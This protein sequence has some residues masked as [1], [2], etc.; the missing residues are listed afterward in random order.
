MTELNPLLAK[1]KMPGKVFQLP[2]RGLLYSDN[3]LAPNISNG[4]LHIQP[5]NAFDEVILKNPDMLFTGQALDPVF[6]ACIQ[7]VQKPTSLLGRDVDAIMLFLRLVT[8]GPSYEILANH[9]CEFGVTHTYV[10]DL[11]QII[12]NMKYL[13]PTTIQDQYK[14]MFENGQVVELT[15]AKYFE[16]IQIL[17]IN[18]GKTELSA[19]DL[20]QNIHNNL[21]SV[22]KSIDGI[23]NKQQIA[24]WIHTAP[25]S[26]I[27][28]IAEQMDVL[29]EWGL[30][31]EL[32]LTCKDCGESFSAELPI[33]PIVFF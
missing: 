11:G 12:D 3:E 8:Y 13:D 32:T 24:E 20:Q 26:Y 18:K 28:K 22:I 15:P 5:M 9:G 31:L 17:Q 21:M 25:A 29:N 33:N 30:D 14:I 2:S 10:I 4:E 1:L 19:Q 7:G 23:T 27:N 16:L 6:S